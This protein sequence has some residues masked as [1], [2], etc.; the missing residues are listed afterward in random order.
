MGERLATHDTALR[1]AGGVRARTYARLAHG[2]IDMAMR[3]HSGDLVARV[4]ADVDELSDVL[5]RAVVPIAVAGV[6]GVAGLLGVPLGIA[7]GRWAWRVV[8]EQLGVA[9]DPV[10]P[11]GSVL[12]IATGALLVANLVAAGPGWA[13]GSPAT[14]CWA[15][16]TAPAARAAMSGIHSGCSV[17]CSATFCANRNRTG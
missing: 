10:V 1:A 5:V 2:P 14:R 12:A 13:A 11:A 17:T 9:A 8:A 16:A 3:R 15:A 6:L 4:G 7:G